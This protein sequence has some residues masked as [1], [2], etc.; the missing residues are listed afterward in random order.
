MVRIAPM[1][2]TAWN[3]MTSGRRKGRNQQ[4]YV[5]TQWDAYTQWYLGRRSPRH[6]WKQ[7]ESEDVDRIT[8]VFY[9]LS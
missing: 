9:R 5:G 6:L 7:D 1:E 3:T 2:M 4:M 8:A